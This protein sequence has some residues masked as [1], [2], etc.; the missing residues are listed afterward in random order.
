LS[1][2][3]AAHTVSIHKPHDDLGGFE[4]EF[5]FD[6]VF[7]PSSGQQQLYECAGANVVERV[8]EGFNGTIFAYGQTGAG[9]TY[10]MTGTRDDPG[11]I[12]RAFRHIF[13][14]IEANSHEVKF[15]I[16]VG[17]LEIYN[18]EIRDLLNGCKPVQL[19][20]KPDGSVGVKNLVW[21]AVKSDIELM[22]LFN[23][24]N[25]N[26]ATG[27]TQMN[28]ES[29][30][31]HS[32]FMLVIE[33]SNQEG[34]VRVGKLNLVD[35]AGSERQ[36]KTGA[37]GDTL[38]EAS[39]INLSLSALGNVI[40]ALVETSRTGFVPY[41]DSKLT[42]LLQDSLGGN[43]KTV[44]I[45]NICPSGTHYEETLST[46]RF[47]ARAKR[48]KNKPRINEDPK[49]AQIR[50]FQE[51]IDRLRKQLACVTGP[52]ANDAD[53]RK[54]LADMETK[55]L[56]GHHAVQT[57]LAA[58]RAELE[59]KARA[60][61]QVRKQLVEQTEERQL[62]EDRFVNQIDQ[63]GELKRK[64]EKVV[65][66]YKRTKDEL[67]DFQTEF[68]EERESL[69]STIRELQKMYKLNEFIINNLVRAEDV[70]KIEKRCWFDDE[71][72]EWALQSDN[73]AEDDQD[74]SSFIYEEPMPQFDLYV[75]RPEWKS[76]ADLF[77]EMQKS[78]YFHIDTDGNNIVRD[79]EVS[80]G[81]IPLVIEERQRPITANVTR[82]QTADRRGRRTAGSEVIDISPIP[83]ARGLIK[84]DI[85]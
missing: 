2:N 65:A 67:R 69:L 26:R 39:K 71:T 64:L 21:T 78:V 42:R 22:S 3:E 83:R 81:R 14:R 59:E 53:L 55:L 76:A 23:Q 41:R 82:P 70:E 11:I 84:P 38:K 40:S 46:L 19:Q 85:S 1:I 77:S 10:T 54:E 6:Y 9:K 72:N 7:G 17:F 51:E 50:G 18:E 66:K 79:P 25:R 33:S 62:L 74:T 29:S 60:E 13:S 61:A 12:P 24:G 63:V 57:E 36:S 56:Q 31:S 48:I 28:A 30:R 37:V 16:Q 68:Q 43:T 80:E 44:M 52:V 4:K 49:D 47:S 35:L 5:S 15:L 8:M 34:H 32:I 45:S 27:S 20:D 75:E 73:E 58:T